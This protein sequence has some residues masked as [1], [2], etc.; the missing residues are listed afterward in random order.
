MKD[1]Q[2][3]ILFLVINKYTN[4]IVEKSNYYSKNYIDAHNFIMKYTNESTTYTYD[5]DNNFIA[6]DDNSKNINFKLIIPYNY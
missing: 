3:K 6:K 1:F 2:Y 5:K 4:I